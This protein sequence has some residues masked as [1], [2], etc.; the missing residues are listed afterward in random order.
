MSAHVAPCDLPMLGR[1]ID[2]LVSFDAIGLDELNACLVAWEHKMGPWTRPAF[3][4]EAFHGLRI[5]GE[6][7]AV[8]AAARLIPAA[9]AGFSRDEAVELGRVCAGR[10]WMNTVAVRLWREVVFRG[11]CRAYGFRWAISYQ[12]RK[13]AELERQLADMRSE[14]QYWN[15]KAEDL[16]A[17]V[18]LLERQLA[19]AEAEGL[20][21]A[22]TAPPPK[23][24]TSGPAEQE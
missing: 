12:D 10:K 5:H 11:L 3:G 13:L 16:A 23:P 1:L 17:L 22:T 8:T 15:S 7:V 4:R 18:A 9:T 24:T 21:V 20:T 19:E 14:R 2:P 6:L